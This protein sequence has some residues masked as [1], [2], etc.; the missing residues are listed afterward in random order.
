LIKSRFEDVRDPQH[1]LEILFDGNQEKDI[2]EDFCSYVQDKD[3]DML[4]FID[5]YA[6]TIL[7]YLF[8]RTVRLGLELDIGREK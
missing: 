3:Q 5:H 4:V 1:N 8:A 2:L 6:G 7:D